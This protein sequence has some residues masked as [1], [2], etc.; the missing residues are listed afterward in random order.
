MIFWFKIMIFWFKIMNFWTKNE[1]LSQCALQL[2]MRFK[3]PLFILLDL[4]VFCCCTLKKPEEFQIFRESFFYRNRYKIG[5][6][7]TSSFFSESD[8]HLP[9]VVKCKSLII[10]GESLVFKKGENSAPLEL[11]MSKPILKH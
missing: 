1:A 8:K 9:F 6:E 11:C 3:W 4:F 5:C 7:M 10:S 2:L